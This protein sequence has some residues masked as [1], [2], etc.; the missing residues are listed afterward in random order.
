MLRVHRGTTD[1][2][3]RAIKCGVKSIFVSI[4]EVETDNGIA[5]HVLAR[6]GN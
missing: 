2:R 3:R 5:D 6:P 4:R 1:K